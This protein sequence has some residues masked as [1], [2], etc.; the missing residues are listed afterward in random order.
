MGELEI[1]TESTMKRDRLNLGN[2]AALAA[3]ASGDIHNAMVAGTP[4]G[5]EAQE[6]AGQAMLTLKFNQL[7]K[8]YSYWRGEGTWQECMERLGFK[9]GADVDD[10]FVSVTPPPGW[11][12]R[13]S[14]HSMHSYI[15]DDQGR[16]RGNVFYKAAFYDRRADFHLLTR[17]Q[18]G[19]DY[20]GDDRFSVARDTASGQILF[21]R[22]PMARGAVE[23][24]QATDAEALKYLD[25]HFPDWRNV[26]A[27]W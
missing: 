11:T 8:E 7:P 20:R 27:Y 25:Q 13:P 6:K 1:L 26:E 19:G 16:M 10:L 17:Y 5:I 24:W 23:Q 21:E 4:G 3:L 15:H 2:P 14:D 9:F 18:G 12:L 22:G